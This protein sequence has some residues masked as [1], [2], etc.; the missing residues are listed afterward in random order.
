M[1]KD[2]EYFGSLQKS[3]TFAP[4]NETRAPSAERS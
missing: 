2:A 3:R 4:A 1:K